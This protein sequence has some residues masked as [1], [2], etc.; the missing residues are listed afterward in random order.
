MSGFK[1]IL[2][3]IL[4]RFTSRLYK[5]ARGISYFLPAVR[6]RTAVALVALATLALAL[7]FTISILGQLNFKSNIGSHG[8][9][10]AFGAGVYWDGNCNNA[11]YYIDWGLVDPGLAKNVTF[12]IRNEGNYPVTLFLDADNWNPENASNYLTL[13]WDYGGETVSPNENIEVT[14]HLLASSE[15]EGITDFSF[16]V[17]ISGS[18]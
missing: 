6:R 12:H 4:K 18:A 16:D 3:T 7:L 14:L 11:V 13:S 5:I 17:V 10:K 8:T 9:V 2:F 1:D 15:I